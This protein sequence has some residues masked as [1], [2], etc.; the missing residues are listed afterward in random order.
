M[1]IKTLAFAL[2][3]TTCLSSA[4]LAD[5]LT[6]VVTVPLG[7]EITGMYLEGGD[8]FFNV[9]HLEVTVGHNRL[10]NSGTIV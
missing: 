1:K 7:A 8:L 5:S 9:W 2:A 6:R 3:A 10:G 4:A